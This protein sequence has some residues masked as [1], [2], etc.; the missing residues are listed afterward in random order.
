[1]KLLPAW[2]L[3][4]EGGWWRRLWGPSCIY[5]ASPSLSFSNHHLGAHLLALQVFT[6]L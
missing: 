1:M 4:N 6:E 3:R 5:L 2:A